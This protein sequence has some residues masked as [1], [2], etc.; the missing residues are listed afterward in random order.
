MRISEVMTANPDTAEAGDSIATVAARM[1]SG[2]FGSLPVLDGGR[3]VGVVT[4]RDIVVRGVARGS[5]PDT[6]VRDV[7][8][9][10]PVCV[11][12]DSDV[13]A[14]AELMQEKQIRRL[15]VT[16]GDKLVGIVA[17]ADV[18]RQGADKLSGE[19]IEAI[20]KK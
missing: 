16:E 1:E 9:P 10:D 15:Y 14:A 5:G 8:T 12:P 2:N 11:E 20:S 6:P 13:E 3:L 4:D 19:T 18:A 17:M 7:M